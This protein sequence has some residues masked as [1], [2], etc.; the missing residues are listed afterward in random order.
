[1]KVSISALL[2]LVTPNLPLVPFFIP[3]IVSSSPKAL[4]EV[5][6]VVNLFLIYKILAQG[7]LTKLLMYKVVPSITPSTAELLKSSPLERTTTSLFATA[8]PLNTLRTHPR[9]PSF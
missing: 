9:P 6:G 7:I 3:A 4:A 8:A 5:T 2:V 1:M